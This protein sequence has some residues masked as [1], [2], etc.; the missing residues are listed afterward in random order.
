MRGIGIMNKKIEIKVKIIEQKN[1]SVIGG[2]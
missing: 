2:D 1:K